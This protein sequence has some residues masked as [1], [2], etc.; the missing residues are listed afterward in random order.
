MGDNPRLS[1]TAISTL[2]RSLQPITT[3]LYGGYRRGRLFD[4][5]VWDL[6]DDPL[7]WG[8]QYQIPPDLVV[9]FQ[10]ID[11]VAIILRLVLRSRIVYKREIK[12]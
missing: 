6:C 10:P 7:V 1:A 9:K 5:V 2:L 12:G 4:L 3:D 11:I 8:A